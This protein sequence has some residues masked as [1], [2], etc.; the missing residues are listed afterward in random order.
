MS[1]RRRRRR[2]RVGS[3][4]VALL[5][6]GPAA[7]LLGTASVAGATTVDPSTACPGPLDHVSFE[8]V[9][10]DSTHAREVGCASW[11]EVAIGG[12]DGWFEPAATTRRDQVASIV[13]RLVDRLGGVLPGYAPNPYRDVDPGSPHVDAIARITAVGIA[14][15]TGDRNFDPDRS[16]TRAQMATLVVHAYEYARGMAL[17]T[18]PDYFTDDEDSVH[19]DEIDKAALAGF[20]AGVG[21]GR[22]DPERALRRDEAAAF[23]VRALGLAVQS[24]ATQ[25]PVEHASFEGTG[26]A[27]SAPFRLRSGQYAA[28]WEY[29]GDC[30]YGPSLEPV[31]PEAD[32]IILP[33]GVGP[34]PGQAPLGHSEPLAYRLHTPAGGNEPCAWRIRL[35]RTG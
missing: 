35:D 21:D 24:G 33:A 8:D 18:G 10:D 27:A 19:E 29:L 1:A 11:W 16:M 22:F 9:P 17:P 4:A 14:Q 5:A 12:T 3:I 2:R 28:S 32:R 30:Y 15:G 7:G 25:V 23:A 13:A 34:A 6:G 26:T 31:D 20:V